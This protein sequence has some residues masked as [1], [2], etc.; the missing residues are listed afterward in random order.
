MTSTY[1]VPKD[2]E[3]FL[4][5]EDTIGENSAIKA[6][7][8]ERYISEAEGEFERKTGTAY[9]PVLQQDEVHDM[10]AWRARH[11]ELFDNEWFAVPRPR[12]TNHAPILPPASSRNH[13]LEV[14]EGSVDNSQNWTDWLADRTQG[15]ANDWWVDHKKGIIYVRKTWLFRRASL[16]RFTYEWGKPIATLDSSIT[17]SDTTITLSQYHSLGDTYRYQNR[18]WVR[19]GDEWIWHSSKTDTDLTN[20]ERGKR[21]TTAQSHSAGDEVIEVPENVWAGVVRYAAAKYLQNEVYQAVTGDSDISPTYK[22][23]IDSW[24]DQWHTLVHGDYQQWRLL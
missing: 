8:V 17:D 19:I 22:Q 24:M 13:K 23:K 11:K 2:V 9:R 5:L 7:Q 10:E 16:I 15:R 6:H 20:C 12:G 21:G 1:A 3:H 14:Y 4:L 18:G